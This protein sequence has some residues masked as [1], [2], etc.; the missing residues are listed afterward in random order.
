MKISRKF[1][2]KYAWYCS[3]AVSSASDILCITMILFYN[4]LQ[5]LL[6]YA[7]VL[8]D[9]R[10]GRV[11]LSTAPLSVL[12]TKM[13]VLSLHVFECPKHMLFSGGMRHNRSCTCSYRRER[14]LLVSFVSSF[15]MLIRV[16]SVDGCRILVSLRAFVRRKHMLLAGGMR[17]S[18]FDTCSYSSKR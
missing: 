12:D 16:K 11:W 1:L 14:R 7:T 17:H 6:P 2:Q 4:S 5:A 10:L 3:S 18:R 8:W 15:G 9:D 13:R